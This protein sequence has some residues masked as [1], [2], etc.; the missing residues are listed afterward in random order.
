MIHTLPYMPEEFEHNEDIEWVVDDTPDVTY[1][2]VMCDVYTT[3]DG[4]NAMSEADEKRKK[5][6]M[7]Y[8]L[9]IIDKLTIEVYKD[10]MSRED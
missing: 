2:S 3:A 7:R 5:R 9:A 4:I 6:I 10:I 8:S 1:L